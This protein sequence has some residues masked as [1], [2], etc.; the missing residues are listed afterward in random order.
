[1]NLRTRIAALVGPVMVI[2][3]L[4]VLAVRHHEAPPVEHVDGRETPSYW[5]DPMHPG[6]HFD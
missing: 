5:Y 1:M 2:A 3:I 6:Q 4:G